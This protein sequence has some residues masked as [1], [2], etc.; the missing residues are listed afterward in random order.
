MKKLYKL[1]ASTFAFSLLITTSASAHVTVKPAEVAPAAFQTFTTSVPNEKDQPTTGVRLVIPEGLKHVSPTVKPGW[2]INMTR[3]GD[4]EDATV[5]EI[6]WS[7]GS[8]GMGLRDEFTFS[9]QVP[10]QETTLAW[11]AY[12]TYQDGTIVAWDQEPSGDG[13]GEGAKTPYSA[14]KVT[15]ESD[16]AETPSQEQS[17]SRA[18]IALGLSI[19]ALVL[20]IGL[21]LLRKK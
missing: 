16:T 5:T 10:A 6:V 12:Q 2:T 21:P 4:D 3:T 13:H 1:L 20:S 8:I 19:L 14:T 15:A 11:K 18:D 9:A 17:N 7:G